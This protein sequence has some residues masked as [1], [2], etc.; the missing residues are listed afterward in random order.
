MKETRTV[1]RE[2]GGTT[3]INPIPNT[4]IF[5]KT[6]A[7]KLSESAALWPAIQ[8]GREGGWVRERTMAG[9]LMKGVNGL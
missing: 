8:H 5:P 1:E 9:V 2:L 6:T 4:K 3:E 7:T